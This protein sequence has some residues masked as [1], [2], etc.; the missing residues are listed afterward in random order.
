MCLQCIAEQGWIQLNGGGQTGLMGAA[1]D[2]GVLAGGIV[3]AVI[4]EMFHKVNESTQLR[5][6]L[7]TKNMRDRKESLLEGG[8]A[9]ICLPGGLVT[10]EEVFEALSWR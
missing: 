4:P 2:G 3:D 5:N 9:V 6:V 8:D 7:V 10:L 1:T